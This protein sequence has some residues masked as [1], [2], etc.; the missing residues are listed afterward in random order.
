MTGDQ[1]FCDHPCANATDAYFTNGTCFASTECVS[2][3]TLRTEGERFY[4]DFTC[5]D[6]EFLSW[7]G[8]CDG[9]CDW[10]H[11]KRIEGGYKYCENDCL[12]FMNHNGT[13]I[14]ACNGPY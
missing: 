2:P 5:D 7:D 3:L 12:D 6:S 4:C 8:G 14:T 10:P 11:S 13:C 1:N 9:F